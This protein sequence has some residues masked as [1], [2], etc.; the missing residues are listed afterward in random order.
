M[1]DRPLIAIFP[2]RAMCQHKIQL[3][4]KYILGVNHHSNVFK[5]NSHFSTARQLFFSAYKSYHPPSEFSVRQ[6]AESL[7]K[8]FLQENI[9]KKQ[10][11]FWPFFD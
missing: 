8:W 7:L 2:K 4:F 11:F 9:A 1:E 6:D 10:I 5:G 3:H